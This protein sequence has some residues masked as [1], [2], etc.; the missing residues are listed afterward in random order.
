MWQRA[1][2]SDYLGDYVVYRNLEPPDARLEGLREMWPRLGL[3]RYSIPR[4]TTPEY[5]AALADLLGQA[6]RARGLR[7]PLRHI[8]F[9]GDT[10]MNDGMTARS[11]G[12]YGRMRAFIG[13][14]RLSQPASV[15]LDGDLMLANRWAALEEFITWAKEGG[16]P[17]DEST[18]LVIDL[19]KTLIGARGR[20][21][22][23]IDAA[24]LDA[25]G[26]T[27]RETLGEGAQSSFLALYNALNQPAYHPFTKDNQDYL[28]YV[29]LMVA[30]GVYGAEVFWQDVQRGALTTFEE[31]V[32]RCEANR[33]AMNAGL[34]QVHEQV[35]YGLAAGDP[36]PFKTFRRAE[37]LETIRRM[38][39]FSDETALEE[40][41]QGEILITAEVAS[42][43]QWAARQG[44]LLFGSSDKPDEA[45][46]PTPDLAQKG[47][48]PLHR[49]VMKVYGEEIV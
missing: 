1:N 8:L 37:Y 49:A 4:K 15:Q 47:Y 43:A 21:D 12:R 9:I 2:V 42:L 27:L 18:A 28:A 3:E 26:R 17:F 33:P 39:A 34:A 11:L 31:F 5:A 20:N 40:I 30:G 35:R 48:V 45:S 23:A 10:A 46:F 36:T 44:V 25:L 24:R 38:D 13:A 41:L 32:S 6:Q 7:T 14:E 16:I 22:R 29:C 19:D